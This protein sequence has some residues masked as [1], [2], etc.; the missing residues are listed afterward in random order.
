MGELWENIKVYNTM[1]IKNQKYIRHFFRFSIK[2]FIKK[3]FFLLVI[4]F[5]R[6]II[7][8]TFYKLWK[9]WENKKVYTVVII[10]KFIDFLNFGDHIKNIF[11]CM[12]IT[13][14]KINGL[15]KFFGVLIL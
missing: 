3:Y 4:I 8:K 1:I 6:N 13:F 7:R 5:I 14:K 2:N 9:M 10:K 11:F 12:I 15:S